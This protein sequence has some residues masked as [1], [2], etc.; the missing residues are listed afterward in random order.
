MQIAKTIQA[1]MNSI[2]IFHLRTTTSWWAKVPGETQSNFLKN[3][4]IL[5][6]NQL[7]IIYYI[8]K[9][10]L[11]WKKSN[12]LVTSSKIEWRILGIFGLKIALL[13][14]KVI[15]WQYWL[16]QEINLNG[17]AISMWNL[18][19]ETKKVIFNACTKYF[20]RLLSKQ[21]IVPGLCRMGI[22]WGN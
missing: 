12:R 21:L 9:E 3:H 18:S 14:L 10:H 5:S 8:A 17:A 20:G 19:H 22:H 13:A 7:E 11:W 4:F 6:L 16:G 2:N 15:Y 1:K